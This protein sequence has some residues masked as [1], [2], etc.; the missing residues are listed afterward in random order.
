MSFALLLYFAKHRKNIKKD[1]KWRI[2]EIKKDKEWF[3]KEINNIFR[4]AMNV[5]TIL[6]EKKNK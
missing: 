2:K 5:Y 1:N 6:F 4:Y 3:V